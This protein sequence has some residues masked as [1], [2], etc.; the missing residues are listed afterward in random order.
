MKV[1]SLKQPFA[2]LVVSG[3]KKIELRNWN[4]KFRG[5][6][7]VHASLTVDKKVMKKF[8]FINLPRGKIIGEAEVVDVKKY[9]SEE[10]QGRDS[11]KHLADSSWGKYGFVLKGSKRRKEVA[12]KG[13]LGFWNYIV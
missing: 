8:G 1:L 5:K 13:K 3:R 7:L 2:E 9:E 4:T 10:A 6:F 12:A 11:D